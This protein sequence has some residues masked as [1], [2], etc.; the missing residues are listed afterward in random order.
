MPVSVSK[1]PR[2]LEATAPPPPGI[3]PD[4]QAII[5]AV[6]G[7]AAQKS[8]DAE[9]TAQRKLNIRQDYAKYIADIYGVDLSIAETFLRSNP[10]ILASL[11]T[12][13]D[14]AD[15]EAQ[16]R[17]TKLLLEME[18][19]GV[20]GQNLGQK[21]GTLTNSITTRTLSPGEA[22]AIFNLELEW[23]KQ[24]KTAP[25]QA[26]QAL[27]KLGPGFVPQSFAGSSMPGFEE[28]GAYRNLLPGMNPEMFK[29]Q[30]TAP[31]AVAS[32]AQMFKPTQNEAMQMA[33]MAMA[34]A[35]KTGIG[36]TSTTQSTSTPMGGGLRPPTSLQQAASAQGI[37]GQ[38]PQLT[39]PIPQPQQFPQTLG[40]P[41]PPGMAPQPQ[42]PQPNML[43]QLWQRL[44]GGR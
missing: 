41:I 26:A 13:F 24:E 19:Q 38:N 36:S 25:L 8:T 31:G 37:L 3:S 30:P 44:F 15:D 32:L 4:V 11:I 29:Y 34:N 12:N 43:Q 14:L 27:Q 16:T 40:P 5:D 2:P 1:T 20:L 7:G 28:G 22:E 35:L 23:Q 33:R 42:A 39:G 10:S 9:V 6:T 17:L 21:L 18:N